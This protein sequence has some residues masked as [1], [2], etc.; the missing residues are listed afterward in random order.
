MRLTQTLVDAASHRP[1]SDSQRAMLALR[2]S[3][4]LTGKSSP[5]SVS[6]APTKSQICAMKR[7]LF[8]KPIDSICK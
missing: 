2:P 7:A 3:Q 1:L 4:P 6:T 8:A 5:V